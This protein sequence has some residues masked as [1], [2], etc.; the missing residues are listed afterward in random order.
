MKYGR[1]RSGVSRHHD[2][3]GETEEDQK[4]K[5]REAEREREGLPHGGV[6]CVCVCVCV[7]VTWGRPVSMAARLGEQLLTEVK[8]FW[9]VR[10]R[11]DSARRFG[12][13][14]AELLYTSVSK[15]ASSAG[16]NSRERTKDTVN[17]TRIQGHVE[18]MC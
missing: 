16:R 18:P 12:V 17:T 7:C 6:V 10:A 9:K 3:S 5:T 4:E 11:R 1:E 2:G 8:A 15:P 13:R 14:T